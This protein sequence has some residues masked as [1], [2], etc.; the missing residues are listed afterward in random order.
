[1]SRNCGVERS[2]AGLADLNALIG[3]MIE[4]H[5]EADALIAA[6]F[7]A[8]GAI[9]RQESRGGHFRTDFPQAHA[10][11]RHTRL[12]LADLAGT[13]PHPLAHTVPAE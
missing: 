2:G 12:S 8:E 13:R 3:D 10:I 11:A 5:G 4:R 9:A 6:R 7:I 1:M